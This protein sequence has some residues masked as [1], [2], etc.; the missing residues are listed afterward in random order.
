MALT[1]KWGEPG[2]TI[3]FKDGTVLPW[4]E[5]NALMICNQEWKDDEGVR[6]AQLVFFFADKNHA[7][8]CLGLTKDKINIFSDNPVT[9][10]HIIRKYVYQWKDIV[11]LFLKAVP[12]VRIWLTQEDDT[13]D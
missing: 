2:G 13:E 3:T 11:D 10:I 7:K 4:Y 5:G 6:N 1:F 12:G 9:E 8:A